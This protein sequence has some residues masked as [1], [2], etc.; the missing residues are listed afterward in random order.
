MDSTAIAEQLN[1]LILHPHQQ[2]YS[3]W[4]GT[5]ILQSQGD[6]PLEPSMVVAHL[7]GKEIIAVRLLQPGTNSAKAG[8]IDFD[9]PKGGGDRPTL[10]KVLQLVLQI[11]QAAAQLEIFT[12]IEFSGRRGFH[13]WLF[14]DAPVPGAT[15]VMALRNLCAQVGYNPKEIY[16][17]TA[18]TA[19]DGKASGRPIKLPCGLHPVSRRR[20]GFLP[21]DAFPV[22]GSELAS[23]I[24]RV[25]TGVSQPE[26]QEEIQRFR[27]GGWL[28]NN[29]AEIV[30]TEGLPDVPEDQA[31]LLMRMQQV[32]AWRIADLSQ[33]DLAQQEG[34]TS[35]GSGQSVSGN[36]GL[37]FLQKS[38]KPSQK[39]HE[40]GDEN[41]ES[42]FAALAAGEHPAC[43]N[44]LC[45][46]GAP[47][48]QDYNAV[49]VTLS[50]YACDRQLTDAEAEELAR[51]M[52]RQSGHHPTSKQTVEAKL[53]NFRTAYASV[54]RNP[55]AYP[56]SC[57][58]VRHSQELVQ[59][60]GCT[61]WACPFWPWER[62]E[63]EHEGARRVERE[64]LAYLLHFPQTGM[65][66]ALGMDLPPEGFIT[67]F[68]GVGVG[69][70]LYLHQLIWRSLVALEAAGQELIPSL[71]L[72]QLEALPGQRLPTTAIN[73]AAQY[74]D[75]LLRS[76]PCQT[77][78][79]MAHLL[80]VRDTGLRMLAQQQARSAQDQLNDRSQPVTEV[81][82]RLITYSQGLQRR[83]ASQI[84]P[85]VAY[86]APLI[87]DL[88]GRSRLAIPTPS[89][90]LNRSLN[91]GFQPGK[92]YVIGAPPGSGKTTW[93]A[94]CG[95]EAARSQIPVLYVSYE[96]GR[97]QLWINALARIAGLNSGLIEGK[98]WTDPEYPHRDWL[99]EQVVQAIRLYDRLV[100]DWLTVVEA[101]PEVTVAHLKGMVAQVRQMTEQTQQAP[102]LVVVDYLQ[103]MPCGDDR[104]DSGMNEVLRVS[105]VATGLKQ[106]ARDAQV[107]VVA[108]SDINKAAYQEALRTGM[109]DMGSLRDSF[110]IAHAADGIML[111]QTGKAQR[112]NE[113]PRD[114]LDLMEE[115]YAHDRNRIRQLQL[116]RNQYP[117]SDRTHS[118]Y[119]RLSILKNRGGM[120]AE[121]LFLYERAYHRFQAIDLD[122]GEADDL[123][124]L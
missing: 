104:L 114:Q 98:R 44:Y 80:R 76:L 26:V 74:L 93:C 103:L 25:T 95:D 23:P 109:L 60:G 42:G 70:P 33:A 13:L 51:Q 52:A 120:T 3:I 30:W 122:L 64:L 81:L 72:T 40:S 123:R 19:P 15:W 17:A 75:E 92:L 54:K 50:R 36:S 117:V 102:V 79:F 43:I 21:W 41:Q 113:A 86:T 12:Y 124:D 27:Q 115:R 107:A 121:P 89:S 8:C 68:P 84:L 20:S 22:T 71:I 57:S 82:E 108:I 118:T 38:L 46:R 31:G 28:G 96:M 4:R 37:R 111:L 2:L 10:E 78:T 66:E 53:G 39:F 99:R 97:Q 5:E 55:T 63:A 67:Q 1:R 45:D 119:A 112:G 49:N 91:G 56:W 69:G 61:G 34:F 24:E 87:Q 65:P 29:L 47:T 9:A 100:A 94:W 35:L 48:D 14:A 116:V 6:R 18:T 90:W 62:P 11:Q 85:M 7:Q 88:F 101:G 58:Y 32:P 105:R 73:R 83:H 16:P 106:L 77:E 110:K 59:A